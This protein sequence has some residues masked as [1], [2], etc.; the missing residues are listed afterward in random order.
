M[1][2]EFLSRQQLNLI[3][4]R[5]TC[6]LKTL[7]PF[8]LWYYFLKLTNSHK[9]T[10]TKVLIV[11]SGGSYPAC[12]FAK[13]VI[14]EYLN[15][16]V[17]ATTPQTALRMLNEFKSFSNTINSKYDLIIG[18]SYSGKT[19]DIVAIAKLCKLKQ[20]PF[21]LITGA[22]YVEDDLTKII[23]Y[24]NARY[25]EAE[26]GLI[27]MAS[28]LIPMYILEAVRYT[29]P[30][31]LLTHPV[32]ELHYGER[33]VSQLDIGKIASSLK[34]TPIIH[35]FYEWDT[36]PT[37]LD[38]E[39]KF[40]ESGIAT[41]ILHEKK[42]FSHGRTTLLYTQKFALV[43]NLCRYKYDYNGNIDRKLN[44]EMKFKNDYD[45]ILT[46]YLK[47]ICNN[48][49]SNYIEL[50]AI[51]PFVT[52]SRWNL[53]TMPILPYLVTQIGEE[54]NIDISRPFK[55]YPQETLALY[56]YTGEF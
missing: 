5:V 7:A 15:I 24:F 18:I 48:F 49:N 31:H 8:D 36:L 32:S 41:V 43:L 26:K 34:K 42:N 9:N 55:H 56:N 47:T 13:H 50:F 23:S 4:D 1:K 40:T 29:L 37:A 25:P 46:D 10:P 51:S 6:A 16:T 53:W 20:Y 11:G 21:L 28:T 27:S 33:F 45:K 22:K 30:P 44:E 3:E 19:P 54:M 38:I 17:E 2:E 14:L 12:V 35:V 39:S 52:S